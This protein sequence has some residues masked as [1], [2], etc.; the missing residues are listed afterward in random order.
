WKLVKEGIQWR[1]LID[2]RAVDSTEVRYKLND[3]V[4]YGPSVYKCIEGHV[5]AAAY[6]DDSNLGVYTSSAL[7]ADA[8]NGA[9][10]D[11]SLTVNGLK[12]VVAA[13]QGVGLIPET[14]VN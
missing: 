9:V 3:I 7:A 14:F 6:I 13:E 8:T 10:F 11:K 1:G 5:P 2:D 4:K 12:I